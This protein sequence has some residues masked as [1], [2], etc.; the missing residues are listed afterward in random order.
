MGDK[1]EIESLNKNPI[2]YDFLFIGTPVWA[3]SF[4][5]VLRTLFDCMRFKDKK[6]ALFCCHAGAKGKVFEKCYKS[7]TLSVS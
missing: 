1:P 4:A 3:G 7:L 6:I 2:E 5:P